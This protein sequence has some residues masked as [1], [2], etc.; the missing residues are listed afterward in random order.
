MRTVMHLSLDPPFRFRWG[1]DRVWGA[2][3][4]IRAWVGCRSVRVF[5][6]GSLVAPLGLGGQVAEA[7]GPSA[8]VNI[9]CHGCSQGHRSGRWRRSRRAERAMRAGTAM[10]WARI[11]AVVAR[12]WYLEARVPAARVRLNEIAARTSYAVFAL[13]CPEDKCASGAPF[14][15]AMTFSRVGVVAVGCLRREHRLL[16]VGEDRVVA[17]GGEQGALPGRERGGVQALDAAHD[18]PGVDVFTVA[19]GGERGESDLGD[20]RVGDPAVLVLVVDRVGVLD[21]DPRVVGD[22]GDRP[23]HGGVHAGGDREPGPTGDCLL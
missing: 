9:A 5:H 8:A 10:S 2:S 15:S 12:A 21:S 22:L 19:A 7:G 11:V 13:I 16:G 18:Q 6:F 3:F 20:L 23:G 1:S 4:L 17:P 14:N